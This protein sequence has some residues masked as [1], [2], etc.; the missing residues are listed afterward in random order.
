MFS[1]RGHLRAMGFVSE[2]FAEHVDPRLRGEISSLETYNGSHEHLLLWHHSMGND[3]LD[4]GLGLPDDI[5]T[6]YH[7]VTPAH[8]FTDPATRY[9]ASLGREQLRIL[10]RRSKVGVAASNYNRREMLAAGFRRVDVLPPRTDFSGFAEAGDQPWRRS[11]DWLFV[12]RVVANKCQ[13]HLVRAFADY[14]RNF[15]HAARLVLIGDTSSRDYVAEVEKAAVEFGVDECVVLLGKVPDAQLR[16]MYAQA[17]VYVSLSE[18]EGFGVPLLEAMASGL[19]VIAYAAAAV[20]ETMG[21]AGILLRTKDPAS[22]AATVQSVS[23]D[24][25]MRQR[26]VLRQRTRVRQVENFDIRGLLNRVITRATGADRPLEIQ[27]QG[28]F[29]TSYSLAIIN[30]QLALGLDKKPGHALSIYATEGPGD[31]QPDPANLAQMPDA[32]ALWRRSAEIPYPDVVIR[33]MWPPRV[34]DSPGAITCECFAWE[35]SG[36]PEGIVSDFNRYL[37]GIGVL[38]HFVKE[39]LRQSGAIVPIQVVGSGVESPDPA[40]TVTAPE[41]E[42][43]R[44]IRFVNIG[45]AFPRKG[46]DVLL[47][48]YFA[49]FDADSDVSLVLKTFP[50]PHNRVREI[51]E[52]LRS[53]YPR[54][55]DV[56]WI[57]RDLSQ[58]DIHGLY[59]L[60]SCYVHPA[61]GEGFGLPVA[62][63]MLAGVPVISVAYSGLA[64]FVSE[65]TAVTIPY[66]ID[67]A[68]THLAVPD[69]TWAEP[70]QNAL[71]VAMRRMVDEP[72]HPEVN[73]RVQ[74]ARELIADRYSWDAVASRW[75]EFLAELEAAAE[76]PRVAMVSTWNSRCGIAEN[77][78]AILRAAGDLFDYEIYAN[79]HVEVLDL[80]A[81][82]GVVRCWT[83]R[84]LPELDR[85]ETALDLSGADVVHFQFNFAFFELSRWAALIRRELTRR[86]VVVSLHRTRDIETSGKLLSLSSI[87]STLK[88]VDRLIVH[89]AADARVLASMGIVDNVRVLGLGCAPPPTVHSAQVRAAMGLDDRPVIAT[90]GFLLPHK[91]IL[92]LLDAVDNLRCQTPRLHLLAMCALHP[93]PTSAA[94]E[95]EVRERIASLGL[96]SNL[97]LITDYL[98]EA[99]VRTLLSSA[100]VIVLPYRHTEES[101]S[102]ALRFVLSASRPIVVTDLPI[103]ADVRDGIVVVDP[104]SQADLEDALRRIL[105]EP[106]WREDLA[107][108]VAHTARR[109][110]W[111]TIVSD[112]RQIY[113][114]ARTAFERRRSSTPAG[115]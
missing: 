113:V 91:G 69:S 37:D 45:S 28:P 39:A 54:G 53:R 47:E 57:D 104:G 64:D 32:T 98:P 115:A 11:T 49:A 99:T 19:P 14:A 105:N 40:A 106:G 89:Q 111:P 71:A 51:L 112:H 24:P 44:S 13:D 110:S 7:N 79:D 33:Q 38:S 41:L 93:D 43:L 42:G 15:D 34:I 83:D 31:Y 101:A 55:P 46:I 8:F 90:F 94:F 82:H 108:Q 73:Q 62:E 56:R 95:I 60:A 27:V 4:A 22:V 36:V 65:A 25:A 17:G 3:A 78:R 88:R 59:N 5:V 86:A 20:P 63:A 100:D 72:D 75:V 103:F 50:N 96:E 58:S 52:G 68:R 107:R 70:D 77:T 1:I 66:R 48:A 80:S 2:I 23:L 29:E 30:R 6:I 87:A 26:L 85:L 92:D 74:R 9:Y 21:G 109:Y 97:T 76:K 12:G 61:R 18:H 35:E 84:W 16:A 10:A 102:S 81:E 67:R 114:A